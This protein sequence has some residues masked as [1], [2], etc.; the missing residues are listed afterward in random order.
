[1]CG[2]RI[3]SKM[4]LEER[5]FVFVKGYLENLMYRGQVLVKSSGRPQDFGWLNRHSPAQHL[6]AIALLYPTVLSQKTILNL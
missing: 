1:M 6:I 2:Y 4:W 5:Y 3:N